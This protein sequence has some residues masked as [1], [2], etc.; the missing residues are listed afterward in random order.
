VSR[1]RYYPGP[2]RWEA[3][4]RRKPPPMPDLAREWLEYLEVVG[5]DHARLDYRHDRPPAEP[6]RGDRKRRRARHSARVVTR[7]V[8]DQVASAKPWDFR[9]IE[10]IQIVFTV[11][12]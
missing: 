10:Q 6:W 9:R 2:R 4:P 1:S 12:F 8:F 7:S 3:N 5:P 11:S